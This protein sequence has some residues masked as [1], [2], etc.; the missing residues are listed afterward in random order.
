MSDSARG[1]SAQTLTAST[2]ET[3]RQRLLSGEWPGG[4]QLRQEALSRE[5][6]VSRVPVREALRQLEAEGLVEIVEHRGAVVAELSLDEI[7][8]LLRVRALL[9]CD[10]LL[11]AVPR[12]TRGDLETAESLLGQFKAALDAR[13]VSRWGL[14]NAEF[15]LT[16]YRAAGRPHTLA[17]IGQLLNRTDRYT[18]IQIML[19]DCCEQSYR[20]H[21]ELLAL[22][23]GKDAVS[24]AASLRKHILDAGPALAAHYPQQ[25]S[26]IATRRS[27]TRNLPE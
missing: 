20:E 19:T 26:G 6:G 27:R 7:L 8:E 22:C 5:L 13:D 15:H 25:R 10:I 12:Q 1:H 11:E 14:L 16:L 17:M 9:E 2:T 24:A 18:R 23:R 3:L 4:T 21:A